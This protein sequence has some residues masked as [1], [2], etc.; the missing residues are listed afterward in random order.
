MV[1]VADGVVTAASADVTVWAGALPEGTVIWS[2][3]GG[4]SGV[5]DT[6]PAVPS[7]SDVA[8][9]FAFQG[10]GTVQAIT[11]EGA[12]AWTASVG[13]GSGTLAD[14]QGG[15]VVAKPDGSIVKLDGLTGQARTLYTMPAQSGAGLG[16]HPDGT[17]FAVRQD[18]G[19]SWSMVG[20]DPVAG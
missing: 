14:F 20:L 6:V 13:A 19:N 1:T 5:N 4:G 17:V 7:A 2:N 3:P 11:S 9:V 12:T 18:G 8:D 10:D 16:V 15:L